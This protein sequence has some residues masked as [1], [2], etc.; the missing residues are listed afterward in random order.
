VVR[1]STTWIRTGAAATGA[2]T[3]ISTYGTRP[4]VPL[5]GDWD[6][7][8]SETPATYEGGVFKVR[9]D[10][11]GGAPTATFS[12]AS[13]A[14]GFPVA[15]DFN[16]DGTDDVAVYRNGLWQVRYS[17]GTTTSFSFGAGTWPATVPV[18]GDWDGNGTDGIGTYTLATG[19]WNLRHTATAGGTPDAGSFL[20]WAG[21]NAS[22]PVVGDWDGNGTD[23]VGVKSGPGWSLRNN[24]DAGAADVTFTFGLSNDLP[25]SWR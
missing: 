14:R 9:N 8:G 17:T 4:L 13:D 19:K 18:A 25:L 5:Y 7:N 12:F 23:T 1:L 2:D 16:G 24:I 21:A 15:G 22:Y 6:G 3:D 20:F 11:L 10:Y